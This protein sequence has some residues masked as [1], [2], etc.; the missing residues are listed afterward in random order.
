MCGAPQRSCNASTA[1]PVPG[2]PGGLAG[3]GGAAWAAARASR[4]KRVRRLGQYLFAPCELVVDR[5]CVR[6]AIMHQDDDDDD[7]GPV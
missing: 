2:A 7:D 3:G 5:T 4:S 6:G 1:I